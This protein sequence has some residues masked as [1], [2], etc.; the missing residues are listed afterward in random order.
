M[1]LSNATLHS[2]MK[3]IWIMISWDIVVK[4]TADLL[5]IISHD[6]QYVVPRDNET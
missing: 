3:D 1:S 4:L 6:W 2:D 5:V